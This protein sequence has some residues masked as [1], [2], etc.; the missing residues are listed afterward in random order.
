MAFELQAAMSLGRLCE[1]QGRRREA[2]TLL[3]PIYQRFTEGFGTA[4][5]IE[6][7]RLLDRLRKSIPTC[8]EPQDS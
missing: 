4:D 5:L 1:T 7:K 3:E 6:A 2:L 8:G